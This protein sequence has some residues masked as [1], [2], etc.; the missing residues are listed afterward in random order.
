MSDDPR[1]DEG[2]DPHPIDMSNVQQLL[3]FSSETAAVH[4]NDHSWTPSVLLT[5][6]YE[7]AEFNKTSV[8]LMVRAS[9]VRDMAGFFLASA[10]RSE[11]EFAATPPKECDHND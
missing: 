8:T 7:D 11:E 6:T 1:N 4:G 2:Y 9:D 10:D 5:L 3:G